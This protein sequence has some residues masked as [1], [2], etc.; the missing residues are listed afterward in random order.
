MDLNAILSDVAATGGGAPLWVLAL[1]A[2]ALALAAALAVY[3]LLRPKC[4]APVVVAREADI[5][6][7]LKNAGERLDL[8]AADAPTRPLGRGRRTKVSA[9]ELELM[10]EG[11]KGWKKLSAGQ[12]VHLAFRPRKTGLGRVNVLVAEFRSASSGDAAARL[13]L[14]PVR[15]FL[16]VKRRRHSRKR[17]IDQQYVRVRLFAADPATSDVDF[18]SAAPD[19]AVN[20]RDARQGEGAGADNQVVNLSQRGIGLRLERAA[21]PKGLETGRRAVLHL[22]LYDFRS[23]SFVPHWYAGVVR[24]VLDDGADHVRMGLEFTA[25]GVEDELG[26]FLT[27]KRL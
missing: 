7:T 18:L 16:F 27:W 20:A 10:V 25:R 14:G 15:G 23:K 17:V 2:G 11:G 24:N 1:G 9:K 8:L 13:L 3:L 19:L 5:P 12:D 21:L 22:S 26:L 4:P 6:K